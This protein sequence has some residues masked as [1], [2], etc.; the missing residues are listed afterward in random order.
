MSPNNHDHTNKPDEGATG[1][2]Q[3]IE[4]LRY[5]DDQAFESLYRFYFPKL[6]QFAYRYVHSNHLAEDLVHNVFF[7]LWRNR[8]HIKPVE[9]LRPYLYRAT[10]NQA[11]KHMNRS[12]SDLMS[13]RSLK[14]IAVK[15]DWSPDEITDDKELENAVIQ[16]VQKLPEKRR[17]IY[18]LHREDGLTYK[19]IAQVLDISIKTVETQ[20]SRSLR[21]LRKCLSDFLPSISMVLPFVKE[22]L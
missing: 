1:E 16:A 11:L 17:Q 8:E 19:E 3:W 15:Q 10:R 5:G 7:S 6:S 13:D 20:M 2:K 22:W 18:L 4:Q 9:S 12:K 21:F 14:S